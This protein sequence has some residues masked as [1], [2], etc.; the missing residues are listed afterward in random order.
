MGDCV[1]WLKAA[2][3]NDYIWES[4]QL[5]IQDQITVIFFANMNYLEFKIKLTG[6]MIFSFLA[7]GCFQM[8]WSDRKAL[9]VFRHKNV[10]LE[11]I[12]TAISSRHIH[13]AICSSNEALPMLVFI[14]G[15]PG[16]WFHYKNYMFDP[17]LRQRFQ[18]AA[19]DRP[20]FGHSDFG[21]ALNLEEQTKLL[22]PVLEELSIKGN[23]QLYLCGHSMGGPVVIKL[24]ADYPKLCQGAIIVA[25]AIDVSQEKKEKWRYFFNK[26]YLKWLLPGAFRP[27]NIELIYLKKD[28][29][30][31]EKDFTKITCPVHFV[32]GDRDTWVPIE[33]VAFGQRMLVNS[34]RVSADT[35]FGADHQIPWKNFQELKSILLKFN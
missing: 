23:R 11:I 1:L 25:G 13:G 17:A 9:S 7:Q 34:T 4:E 5:I 27:S 12:D 18:I 35:I 24:I 22:Y 29:I 33:N 19:L 16:S 2:Q 15:S 26:K 3:N 8:R 21:R 30:P 14:H 20:G 31:L 28:L 10:P 6:L 32:H